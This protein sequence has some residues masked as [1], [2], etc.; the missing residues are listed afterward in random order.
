MD[1]ITLPLAVNQL[2][3]VMAALGK[4]PYEAVAE[5]IQV[6][7]DQALPQINKPE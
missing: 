4:A 6:L 3:V 5:L 1:N 7:R 2:N